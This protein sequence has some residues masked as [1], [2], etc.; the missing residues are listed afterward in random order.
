M[1]FC[2]N[3]Q[4][5]VN[6]SDPEWA[7]YWTNYKMLKKLIKELPSLVPAD[8]KRPRIK[9]EEGFSSFPIPASVAFA[10][11]CSRQHNEDKTT[12]LNENC[13]SFSDESFRDSEMLQSRCRKDGINKSP[14]E[15]AFF[16]LLHAEFKK[17]EHFFGKAQEEFVIR[18]GRVREG[19]EIMKHPNSIMVGDKWSLLAKSL[20]RLYKELLLLETFAVMTYC[21]FSKILKKHDKV[22]GYDT[23]KAF[24]ANVVNKANFTNYP[25]LLDMIKRCELLYEEVSQRLL[26]EGKEGLY[27]DERLFINMIHRLN[28][29][30]TGTAEV[31]GAPEQKIGIRRPKSAANG[32]P[33]TSGVESQLSSLQMIMA[34]M[35]R[36]SDGHV[37]DGGNVAEESGFGRDTRDDEQPP[38]R[39]K[40][41]VG[42][43]ASSPVVTGI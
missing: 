14:G 29:Q 8:D 37:S 13:S 20:Y 3:L 5:V 1:K 24:M 30:C 32:S 33:S 31:E 15:I 41:R 9:S 35:K 19:I 36:N 12:E 38:Q 28:E 40:A 7:P 23:R 16:K 34:G 17:A 22:T 43:P 27:E 18:E 2:K 10:A 26:E 6:I 21:S 39:K 25:I 42:E 4:R 11:Q